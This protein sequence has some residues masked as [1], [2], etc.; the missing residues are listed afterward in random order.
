M[1]WL[2]RFARGILMGSGIAGI[3]YS[4]AAFVTYHDISVWV[5]ALIGI[6]QIGVSYTLQEKPQ[7]GDM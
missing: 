4:M 2:I 5:G 1:I 6:F 7:P 3:I